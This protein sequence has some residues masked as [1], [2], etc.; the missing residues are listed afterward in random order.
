MGIGEVDDAKA[1]Y[2]FIRFT[3]PELPLVLAGFSFGTCV[4]SQLAALVSHRQLLL[5]GPA[6]TRYQV[7]VPDVSKTI[8]VHGEL[9]EVIHLEAVLQWGRELDQPIIWFPASG[10]FFHGKLISL[11]SLLQ[12]LVA[13]C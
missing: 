10:H 1:V 9:D 13:R 7:L 11:T 2:E 8:V 4:A 12:Q 3:Y 6:V 5:V